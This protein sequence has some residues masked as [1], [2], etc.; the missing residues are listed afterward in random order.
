MVELSVKVDGQAIFFSTPDGL[1]LKGC[2]HLPANRRPPVVIGCHGLF[3]SGDSPKQQQLARNCNQR[4]LAFFRFD[5]RGCGESEGDFKAVTSL[6]GRSLDLAGAVA[7]LQARA[8]LGSRFGFFGSSMGGTVCLATASRL[9]PRALVT[10]AAPIRSQPVL[11]AI[12][13]TDERERV[14][15]LLNP[16]NLHFDISEKIDGVHN[17][18][19]F[20]GDADQVVPVA[21][22]HE[23]FSRAG[24]PKAIRIQHRGDHQMSAPHDQA[25]FQQEAADWFERCLLG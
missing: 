6:A 14:S 13:R 18:M 15:T 4:G 24:E 7:M 5:H 25:A 10:I 9:K 23:I 11:A 8:D 1:T 2:L 19:I 16:E 12:D 20:H 22:A 21:N 3:S 17:L